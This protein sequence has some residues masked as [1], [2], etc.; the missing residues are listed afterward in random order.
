MFIKI[1]IMHSVKKTVLTGREVRAFDEFA[2]EMS[3]KLG[4]MSINPNIRY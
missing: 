3:K 2:S 1:I 4:A